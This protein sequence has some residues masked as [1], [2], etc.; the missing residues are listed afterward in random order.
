MIL[1]E[2]LGPCSSATNDVVI[3]ISEAAIADAGVD[4]SECITA[5]TLGPFNISGLLKGAAATGSWTATTGTG[6]FV[7][8]GGAFPNVTAT[9]TPTI[10]D[11]GVGWVEFT[12]TSDA[13]GGVNICPVDIDILRVFLGAN[14]TV[15]AGLDFEVCEDPGAF[16]SFDLV[17]TLAG[18]ATVGTWAISALEPGAGTLTVS[19]TI[20]GTVTATYTPTAFDFGKD[21]VFTLTSNDPAGCGAGSD[22]VIVEINKV[23]NVI[24]PNYLINICDGDLT[25]IV[26]SSDVPG[27]NF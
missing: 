16:T 10:A 4:Y 5:A 21:L 26:L 18:G 11:L 13:P 3:T 19:T 25:N 8:T 20:A 2:G 22:D 14:N 1:M 15:D 12:L 7:N 9:Y 24:T 6:A 23:P 27:C 17:G